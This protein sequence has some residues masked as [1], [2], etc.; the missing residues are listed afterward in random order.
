ME[1]WKAAKTVKAEGADIRA[2]TVWSL[3]GTVDWNSLLVRRNGVYEPGPFDV[4]GPAPRMTALARAA[5]SLAQEGAYNHP[6]LDRPGWWRRDSRFYRPTR[7]KSG[8]RLAG[9]PRSLLITGATG[10]LGR[11][12]SRVCDVRG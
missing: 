7:Q 4:R 6:V 11:A 3:F 10:T 8:P 9:A 12:L 1:V 2:V 5:K